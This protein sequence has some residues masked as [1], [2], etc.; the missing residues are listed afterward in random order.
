M[1]LE[2]S[3]ANKQRHELPGNTE[4]IAV[5]CQTGMNSDK[6]N[7]YNTDYWAKAA[8]NEAIMVK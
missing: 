1:L 8:A 3:M 7:K 2:C 6:D 5:T 4:I